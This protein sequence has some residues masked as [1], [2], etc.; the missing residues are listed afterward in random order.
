M[1][2]AYLVLVYNQLKQK[3]FFIFIIDTKFLLG[4]YFEKL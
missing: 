3:I 4:F 2:H 1:F